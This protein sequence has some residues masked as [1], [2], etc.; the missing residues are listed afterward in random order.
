MIDIVESAGPE[1]LEAAGNALVDA[2]DAINE[3]ADELSVNLGAVDWEGE[4]HDAFYTWGMDLVATALALA[5]YADVV[6]TQVMAA[7]S[8]LASVRKSMPPRD[9]RADPKKVDDIP[10]A[11]RVDSNDEYT[12]AVEAEKHRQEAIN[13]MY[14]LASFYTVSNGVMQ[15]AEEPVFPK[16][17]SVGVPQPAVV[18]EDPGAPIGAHPGQ[19]SLPT[20][21]GSGMYQDLADSPAGRPGAEGLSSSRNSPDDP[22]RSP[23]RHIGTEI[24]SIGTLPPQEAMKPTPV[25]PPPTTGP[26]VTSVG[27]PPPVASV[28]SPP[29]SRNPAG[30]TSGFGGGAAPRTPASA[31]GAS[32]WDTGREPGRTPG[33]RA[34]GTGGTCRHTRTDSRPCDWSHGTRGHWRGAEARRPGG[35]SGEWRPARSGHRNRCHQPRA[36]RRRALRCRP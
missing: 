30:R 9:T 28:A 13:Q 23:E 4:A 29:V 7:G 10:E 14:R 21:R 35:R 11:Q 1:L 33:N 18:V 8:G 24:D 31:Q 36:Y 32:R 20:V 12:A 17:P 3:A 26:N 15:T 27:P 16:M 6:G 34:H 2:R 19:R 5:D 25:T 22:V